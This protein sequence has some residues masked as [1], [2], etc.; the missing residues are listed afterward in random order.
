MTINRHVVN[1]IV[2]LCFI[3]YVT[4]SLILTYLKRKRSSS[5]PI[6]PVA[7]TSRFEN[8]P[9]P[10]LW[11][12]GIGIAVADIAIIYCLWHW[13][14]SSAPQAYMFSGE[15]VINNP[16]IVM[17]LALPV[18]FT[19]RSLLRHAKWPMVL[20]PFL[21]YLTAFILMIWIDYLELYRP[22]FRWLG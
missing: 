18:G 3:S 12:I 19:L 22:F 8:L 1:I 9:F 11:L 2:L 4:I 21:V 7:C 14:G 13:L 6:D 20:V 17:A 15:W 5:E 10:L 16:W